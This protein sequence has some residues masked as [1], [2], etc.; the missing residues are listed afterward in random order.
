M[1]GF[2]YHFEFILDLSF[3]KDGTL[4][5]QNILADFKKEILD[6]NLRLKIKRETEPM[7]NLILGYVFS[8]T[9]LQS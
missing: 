2:T 5:N 8:K 3:D 6:Q 4:E 1:W 9:G 7:R